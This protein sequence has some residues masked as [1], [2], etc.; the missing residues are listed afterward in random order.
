M[1][2][3]SITSVLASGVTL[4]GPPRGRMTTPPSSPP[5]PSPS[6]SNRTDGEKIYGY[7][8]IFS[9]RPRPWLGTGRVPAAWRAWPDVSCDDLPETHHFFDIGCPARVMPLP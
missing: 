2:G 5:P 3:S 8:K 9:R 7:N 6:A 1:F 4:D